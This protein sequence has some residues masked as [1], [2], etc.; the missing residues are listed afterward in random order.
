[1]KSGEMYTHLLGDK[2]I[3]RRILRPLDVTCRLLLGIHGGPKWFAIK[4]I[5]SQ[6]RQLIDAERGI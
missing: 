5:T 4:G 3:S 2:Y 6:T 1:M